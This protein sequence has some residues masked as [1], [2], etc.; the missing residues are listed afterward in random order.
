[1]A[2]LDSNIVLKA[3]ATPQLDIAGTL[4]AASERK[5]QMML[6]GRQDQDYQRQQAT[7]ARQQQDA[8]A[9]RGVIQQYGK[10][11][12]AARKSAFQTGNPELIAKL[13]SM[14]EAG[15]KRTIDVARGTAPLVMSLQKV[16]AEQTPQ[17]MQALAPELQARGWSPEHIAE[18]TQQLSDPGQREAA[19]ASIMSSAQ[20]IEEYAASRKPM[21]V[22]E[23]QEMRLPDG[24]L[25]AEG[26]PKFHAVNTPEGVTTTIYGAPG[27]GGGAA[28]AH[29]GPQIESVVSGF[30]PGVS[31]TS[32]KRSAAHN[33][34]VGGVSDSYHMS[35]N[36]R[37]FVPPKGMGMG[38]LASAIKARLPGYDVI[39]EGDH[40]HVEPG[41]GMARGGNSGPVTIQGKPKQ[42][43]PKQGWTT[44]TPQEAVAQGLPPGGVYQRG[45][46]GEIKP[47]SGTSS[48]QQG[49]G[50]KQQQ[51]MAKMK[52]AALRPIE[53]QLNR[54]E[55][56][57]TTMEKDGYSG[58]VLGNI[59]G[60]LDAASG[61]FDKAVAGLAP[62]IRQLTRVPGEGSTSDYESKLAQAALLSRTD[63]PEARKEALAMMR[64]LIVNI[65]AANEEFLGA[66]AASG[67][68]GSVDDILRKHGVM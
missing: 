22:G 2:Q 35:D 57:M 60:A 20:T 27:S 49:T 65:R 39:N 4:Q 56:A 1:M 31:V 5:R 19:F 21:I 52:I 26:K 23:N 18:V 28:P 55:Q 32:G 15:R 62:L 50:T 64:E 67:G 33:A 44:M 25:I 9:T 7:L 34:A 30:L 43:A 51:G 14:D 58:Y 17:A 48:S 41:P 36:A 6:Q 40:V 61:T 47:V 54:V 13:D 3:F 10:D 53:G 37:D 45:P 8:D 12:M 16:P 68:G 46:K 24:T 11:P 42:V 38:T 63:T 66:P 29:L 59:P